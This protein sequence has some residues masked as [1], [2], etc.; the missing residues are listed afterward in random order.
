MSPQR[1]GSKRGSGWK[2]PRDRREV[3]IAML[4]SLAVIVVTATLI[5][6]VRPNRDSGT[7]TTNDT[8]VTTPTTV[9]GET[10]T[11]APTTLPAETTAPATTSTP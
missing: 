9:A 2:P 1:K 11:L 10:T 4:A 8:T 6:F 7:T 5:W 3:A